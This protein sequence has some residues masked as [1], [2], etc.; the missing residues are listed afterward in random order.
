[1]KLFPCYANW[2]GV[3]IIPLFNMQISLFHA[4][5]QCWSHCWGCGYPNHSGSAQD[6]LA[7]ELIGPGYVN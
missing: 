6:A 3:K 7:N 5:E 1:M 2:P 4:N